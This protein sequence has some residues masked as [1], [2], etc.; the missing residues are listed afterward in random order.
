MDDKQANYSNR[1]FGL[2][3]LS[4]CENNQEH[5]NDDLIDQQLFYETVWGLIRTATNKCILHNDNE[6]VKMID[7][8]L[9]NIRKREKKH[10]KM[11]QVGISKKDSNL[12]KNNNLDGDDDLDEDD[13]FD[14]DNNLNNNDLDKENACASILLKNP[15]VVATK[16]RPKSASHH[17]NNINQQSANKKKRKRDTS[18]NTNQQSTNKKRRGLNL[19]NYCKEP[20]HNI[21]RCSK[22][23]IN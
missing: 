22:K 12:E 2:P 11:H 1:S 6:F 20:D 7:N 5:M 23:I 21:A 15:L 16:G 10:N 8:Y 19:C 9:N 18:Y 4:I 13:N 17:M 3:Q 14:E